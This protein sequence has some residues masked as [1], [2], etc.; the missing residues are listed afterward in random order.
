MDEMDFAHRQIRQEEFRPILPL[1]MGADFETFFETDEQGN[2]DI[3]V[4]G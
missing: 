2:P 3:R 4:I 1:M